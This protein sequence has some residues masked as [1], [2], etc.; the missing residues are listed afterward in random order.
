VKPDCLRLRGTPRDATGVGERQWSECVAL[1]NADHGLRLAVRPSPGR[2]ATQREPTRR[3]RQ[4][5]VRPA[6]RPPSTVPEP[7]RVSPPVSRRGEAVKD[8]H[9]GCR[10]PFQPGSANH[11][12]QLGSP[13]NSGPSATARIASIPS[14]SSLTT[15]VPLRSAEISKGS[16][17]CPPS[18][19]AVAA[20]RDAMIRSA[21]IRKFGTDADGV[22]LGFRLRRECER[23]LPPTAPA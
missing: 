3:L 12:L 9:G 7:E 13:G 14:I 17:R 4:R 19:P 18:P 5:R 16:Q 22:R 21:K 10:W 8:C 20:N 15:V 2:I 1:T 11:H 6:E 23:R